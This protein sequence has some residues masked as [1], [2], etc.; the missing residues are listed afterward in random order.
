[1]VAALDNTPPRPF[2][3]DAM[4]AALGVAWDGL[5]LNKPADAPARGRRG[6][7]RPS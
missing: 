1:M 5:D 3:H 4:V 2:D 6:R 7:R